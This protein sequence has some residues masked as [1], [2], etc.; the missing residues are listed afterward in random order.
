M[1]SQI[2]Q[3]FITP[4]CHSA[5]YIK[6]VISF[7]VEPTDIDLFRVESY[8]FY[9]FHEYTVHFC[10]L[11][12]TFFSLCL[13]TEFMAL[14]A[15][16]LNNYLLKCNLKSLYTNKCILWYIYNFNIEIFNI[17]NFFQLLSKSINLNSMYIHYICQTAI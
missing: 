12:K 15:C 8:R 16:T 10:V 14:S 3:H 6:K 7:C 13:H 11:K 1:L 17:E 2:K 5:S 4:I 9:F